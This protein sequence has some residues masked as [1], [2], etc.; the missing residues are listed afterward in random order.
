MTTFTASH[1]H[2]PTRDLRAGALLT[3]GWI[4]LALFFVFAVAQPAARLHSLGEVVAA[5]DPGAQR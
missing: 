5:A 2:W 1:V 4:A 3:V